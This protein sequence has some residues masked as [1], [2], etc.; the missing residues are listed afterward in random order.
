MV[1]HRNPDQDEVI[2]P[3]ELLDTLDFMPEMKAA[4]D[5]LTPGMKRN[6][7]YWVGSGKTVATR[8]K[9]VAE[10]LRRS[11]TGHAWFAK[12]PQTTSGRA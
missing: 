11:E 3:E 6:M 1:I 4:W 5:K 7:C 9:R 12:A 8:A 2:V 10:I